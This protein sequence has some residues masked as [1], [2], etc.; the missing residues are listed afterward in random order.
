MF[1]LL[2]FNSISR[3][4][5]NVQDELD[6]YRNHAE[7]LENTLQD[8]RAALDEFQV[9]SREL[10]EELEKELQTTE[11]AYK[12][13]KSQCE[14]SRRDAD[15]WKVSQKTKAHTLLPYSLAR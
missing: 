5:N 1:D 2:F 8:T 14:R 10:E 12:E 7:N 3:Q 6:Y 13:L 9:S 4:F 11:K 15:E